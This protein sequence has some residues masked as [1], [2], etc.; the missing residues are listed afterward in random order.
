MEINFILNSPLNPLLWLVCF[1]VYHF[2]IEHIF[3]VVYST[4]LYI[5]F[6]VL[7][8]RYCEEEYLFKNLLLDVCCAFIVFFIV[9]NI[10]KYLYK[11]KIIKNIKIKVVCTVL[12]I[13]F[14]CSIALNVLLAY[15]YRNTYT[16]ITQ[17]KDALTKTQVELKYK[18]VELQEVTDKN[19]QLKEENKWLEDEAEHLKKNLDEIME[20]NEQ[21]Y[22]DNLELYNDNINLY[23]HS[24]KTYY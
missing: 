8:H 14:V 23:Y 10:L 19:K 17:L 9:S 3:K 4:A 22:D 16:N 5:I 12:C 11:N 21:L 15:N 6:N 1:I 7:I 2:K 18:E 20:E 13:L 24:N